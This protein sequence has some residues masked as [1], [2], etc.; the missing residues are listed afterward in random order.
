[1]NSNFYL[2]EYNSKSIDARTKTREDLEFAS[3]SDQS[4]KKYF[5][6]LLKIVF[7]GG[8]MSKNV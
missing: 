3:N 4:L 1:M 2:L 5:K 8:Q 6:I 7:I